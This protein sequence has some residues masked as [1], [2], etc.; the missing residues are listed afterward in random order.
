MEQLQKKLRQKIS[1]KQ[2]LLVLDDVWNENREL[3]LNLRK[4]LSYGAKGSR[5]IV[6]TRSIVVAKIMSKVEPYFLANL[7]EIQSW[8]LF[9]KMALDQEEDPTNSNIMEIGKNIVKSCGGNPLAIRT[10]G[11]MLYFKNPETEWSS[12]LKMEF[13]KIS[14]D[15]NDILPTLKLSYNLLSSH[16]KQCFAYCSLFPKDHEINVEDLIKLWMAQGFIKSTDTTQS[17]EDVGR[18]CFM[19]LYWRSF[20][21]EVEKDVFGNIMNCKMHDVMHD[22]AIQVA[23]ECATFSSIEE[24]INKKTRHVSFGFALKPSQLIPSSLSK[25][26]NRLRTILLPS[27]PLERNHGR[28]GLPICDVIVSNFKF[29]RVLDMNNSGIKTV[30]ESIWKLKHLRYLDLSNTDI[31]ALPN[32]ITKLQNLQTLKLS[33]L[34]GFKE[35]PKD[36]KN[37]VNLRHLEFDL[38][39]NLQHMPLGELTNLQ[40]L[41]KFVLSEG[42]D[43]CGRNEKVGELKELM[44]L[45]NLRGQLHITNLRHAKDSAAANLKEKQYLQSL[46]LD[47]HLPYRDV[48]VTGTV[49]YEMILEGF[50]PHPNLKEVGLFGYGGVRLS[51]WLPSL[52][53]LT[54]FVL[55][56]CKKCLSLP[57]LDQFPSLKC[58]FL[59]DMPAIEYISN[60]F[61]S[62]ST[63]APL[64][65]LEHLILEELPNLKGWWRDRTNSEDN[66]LIAENCMF[67]QFPC[68]SSFDVEDCPRL[69]FMPLSPSI[70]SLALGNFTWK[71]FH[72][73]MKSI[74]IPQSQITT[75]ETS[76]L[77]SFALLTS[78]LSPLVSNLVNLGLNNIE[79]LQSLPNCLV[80]LS[81]LKN[82]T[83][84]RC[85]KLKY[86]SPGIQHLVSLRFLEIEE[87]NELDMSNADMSMWQSLKSLDYFS[88]E[89]L[90]QLET[91]PDGLQH[92]TTLRN[93][94]IRGCNSLLAIPEWISNLSSLT[95]LYIWECPNLTSLPEG[96]RSISSLETLQIYGCPILEQRCQR[97][98]GED[99]PEIAH[100]PHLDLWFRGDSKSSTIS[101]T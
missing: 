44:P 53:Q 10:I 23:G 40:T 34:R 98:K 38:W 41:S 74:T 79:D 22:L 19:D 88:L 75:E 93:L 14:Q 89:N 4:L 42:T 27:Q 71:P 83:I 82:M 67:L 55:W 73:A 11:R 35:L 78:Y 84:K 64:P 47:W 62:S 36:F 2:Y 48:D 60:E 20:F 6:T 49:D 68:L 65:S 8:S 45:N 26:S 77:T 17:L 39:T 54:R 18:E 96:I 29:L 58:L 37:L 99:W 50:Y 63:S 52:K 86:L 12:F 31:E 33:R 90:P 21:Q 7:D 16:L 43:I 51:S 57:P 97:E 13:S 9:K 30:S 28:S 61:Y 69:K 100:I 66:D 15:E 80:S 87:C 5:I 3:W 72:Q 94:N 25:T 101:G 70:K 76:L 24:K 46:V 85:P 59:I 91:L 92:L 95:V 32:S 56:K 81:S 1:G